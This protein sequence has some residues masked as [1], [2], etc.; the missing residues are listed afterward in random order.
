MEAKDWIETLE[1]RP[2]PEG[3]FFRETYRAAETIARRHLPPRFTLWM[4]LCR[5]FRGFQ[6]AGRTI[7]HRFTR[8]D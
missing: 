4:R 6:R 7:F 5:P 1:L 8:L 2:H 3:G